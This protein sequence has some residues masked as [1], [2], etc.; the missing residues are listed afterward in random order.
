MP[1]RFTAPEAALPP[2]PVLRL[3]IIPHKLPPTEHHT[4]AK[5]VEL[6]VT[7]LDPS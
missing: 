3:L 5:P 1:E 2:A 4:V 6:P 7:F